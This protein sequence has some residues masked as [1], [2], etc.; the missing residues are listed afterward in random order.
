LI[1]YAV[2]KKYGVSV[3]F[4][5]DCTYFNFLNGV[6]GLGSSIFD[7]SDSIG[8]I[9]R[10][11]EISKT[12]LVGFSSGGYASLFSSYLIPCRKYLGFSIASDLSFGS[13]IFPGKFF[14]P[15]VRRGIDKKNLVNLRNLAVDAKDG[16]DRTLIFGKE[17]MVDRDHAMNMAGIPALTV[18]GLDNCDH[19]TIFHMICEGTFSSCIESFLS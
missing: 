3:L 9:I 17:S 10:E 11:N 13:K 15:E 16:V 7:L 14:T 1:F 6:E 2:L 8:K 4:L 18:V 12:Y 19:T 5:K